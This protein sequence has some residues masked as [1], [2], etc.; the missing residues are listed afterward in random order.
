MFKINNIIKSK[1]KQMTS[2]RISN[3]KKV[4]KTNFLIKSYNNKY[5]KLFKL[6]QFK[7]NNL[8]FTNK[9]DKT[10]LNKKFDEIA[11]KINKNVKINKNNKFEEKKV[12]L[13]KYIQ[14]DQTLGHSTT[15]Y[16]KRISSSPNINK[17]NIK[18]GTNIKMN[19]NIRDKAIMQNYND[20]KANSNIHFDKTLD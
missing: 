19:K 4:V 16:T 8:L 17:N 1:N 20:N 18:R 12:P 7:N 5:M 14:S 3:N 6:T 15:N 11:H 2:N 10:N 9:I 13:W